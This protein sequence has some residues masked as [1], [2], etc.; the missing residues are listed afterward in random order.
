MN[1]SKILLFSFAFAVSLAGCSTLGETP[2]RGTNLDGEW[3]LDETQSQ[4]P[5][6]VLG[7]NEPK[8]GREKRRELPAPPA[9][10]ATAGPPA[11][12]PPAPP[13]PKFRGPRMIADF[14][15]Q[16]AGL[17]IKQTAT[18]LSLKED[19]STT[20]FVYGE[21][22]MASVEDGASER[23]SGWSEGAF[24]IRYKVF[25]GP[26]ATR[27]Y[28]ANRSGQQL[29]VTTHVSGGYLPKL[30]FRTVYVRVR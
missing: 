12:G 19:G 27:S 9:D 24:V 21:K 17:V 3:K 8:R 5:R 2:S 26:T 6:A 30:D 1:S 29:I 25:D 22:V 28:L 15:T 14:M 7:Q 10:A 13:T 4:D 23:R 18:E 11:A 16:P 20:D